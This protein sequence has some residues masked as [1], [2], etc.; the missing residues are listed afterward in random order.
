M[1]QFLV[2]KSLTVIYGF[3]VNYEIFRAYWNGGS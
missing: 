2:E 1:S 3:V